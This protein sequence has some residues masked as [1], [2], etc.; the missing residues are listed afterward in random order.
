[1]Y[2]RISF[3]VSKTVKL[4]RAFSIHDQLQRVNHKLNNRQ[5]TRHRQG[6]SARP[7]ASLKKVWVSAGLVGKKKNFVNGR[8]LVLRG[9]KFK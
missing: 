6:V 5:L 2:M 9:Y 8:K 1:M 4:I 7:P 3:F